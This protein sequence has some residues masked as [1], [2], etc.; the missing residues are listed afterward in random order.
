[1]R[2]REVALCF[3]LRNTPSARSMSEPASARSSIICT[4]TAGSDFATR[5]TWSRSLLSSISLALLLGERPG[6]LQAALGVEHNVVG[7][8]LLD[9]DRSDT[10]LDGALGP[11]VPDVNLVGDVACSVDAILDLFLLVGHPRLAEDD[12]VVRSVQGDGDTTGLGVDE[13]DAEVVVALE[14]LH[15][16]ERVLGLA[17]DHGRADALATQFVIPQ[18]QHLRERRGHDDLLDVIA[19]VAPSLVGAGL[20]GDAALLQELQ[21]PV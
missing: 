14:Q 9:V 17:R 11:D 21:E 4:M 10:L 13:A 20:G 1:M 5:R 16:T 12:D 2:S 19:Q 8:A 6:E 18:F 3:F 15:L 7:L